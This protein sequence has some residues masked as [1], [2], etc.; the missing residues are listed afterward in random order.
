MSKTPITDLTIASTGFLKVG[1]TSLPQGAFLLLKNAFDLVGAD[2]SLI[3]ADGPAGAQGDTGAQGEPGPQGEVG[4]TGPAGEAGA[5]GE[6]GAQGEVGPAGEPGAQGEVGPAGETG[7]AG[8]RGYFDPLPVNFQDYSAE[9][10]DGELPAPGT[11]FYATDE[12]NNIALFMLNNNS[13]AWSYIQLS[14]FNG[15]FTPVFP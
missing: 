12:G 5:A 10:Y 1:D 11:M 14:A 15:E 4:E 2:G 6:P 9:E 3:G 8:P 13:R 7:P